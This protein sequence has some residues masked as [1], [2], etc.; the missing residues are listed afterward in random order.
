MVDGDAASLGLAKFLS[1][2]SDKGCSAQAEVGSRSD[3]GRGRATGPASEIAAESGRRGRSFLVPG[4][5]FARDLAVAGY[6]GWE[7]VPFT[8]RYP[9]GWATG[10]SAMR[11]MVVVLGW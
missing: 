8:D 11:T 4:G 10:C 2:P 9:V 1:T 3:E 7:G 5:S 6:R